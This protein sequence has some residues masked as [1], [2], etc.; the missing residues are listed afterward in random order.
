M[1]IIK[2]TLGADEIKNVIANFEEV[3]ASNGGKIVESKEL[4]QRE[5]AYEIKNVK[6]DI[7]I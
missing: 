4:G 1:F 5:L 2:P 3:L 7:I 6:V